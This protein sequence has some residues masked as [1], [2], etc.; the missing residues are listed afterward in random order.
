MSHSKSESEFATVSEAEIAG[1]SF[2]RVLDGR[3]S[4]KITC[5][6]FADVMDPL[7]Q[8]IGF[9]TN[10]SNLA[11]ITQQREILTKTAN[12]TIA[13]TNS[14]ILCDTSSAAITITLPTAASAFT[15]LTTLGQQFTVKRI[16]T[17]VN[18]VTIAPDGSESIDGHTQI[19]L[20]GPNL[21]NITFISD[22]T[23]WHVVG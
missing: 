5:T 6:N 7:L 20:V 13:L 2:V 12:Y 23:S 16:T 19:D 10:T 9:L 4:R 22:G 21:V 11:S 3:A 1:N 18:K 8:S 15:S 17:D 14:V